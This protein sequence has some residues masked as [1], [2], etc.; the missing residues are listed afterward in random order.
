MSTWPGTDKLTHWGLVMPYATICPG[1]YW[2]RQWLLTSSAPSHN[3]KHGYLIDHW[4]LKNIWYLNKILLQITTDTSESNSAVLLCCGRCVLY[5][6]IAF[7]FKA[8]WAE[9]PGSHL[10][11]CKKILSRSIEILIIKIRLFW[12]TLVQEIACCPTATLH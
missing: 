4:T 10:N 2:S 6:F 8:K 5:N 3:L 9:K 11:T 12:S 7:M 1:H